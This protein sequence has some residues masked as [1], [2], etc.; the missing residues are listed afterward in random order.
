MKPYVV[1]FLLL[2]CC[3]SRSQAQQAATIYRIKID[4]LQVLIN[5]QPKADSNTVKW[6]NYVARVC[7]YDMQYQRGLLATIE[8]REL[9]KKLHYA[10]GEGLYWR[11]L[12]IF[13]AAPLAFYYYNFLAKW[14]YT[15]RKQQEE[16]VRLWAGL[17]GERNVEKMKAELL[18]ALTYFEKHLDH[19]V[20]A[21]VLVAYASLIK[22]NEQT[23][24][25]AKAI[26]LFR[27]NN[28]PIPPFFIA[29]VTMQLSGQAGNEKETKEA[30]IETRTILATTKD[31]REKASMYYF[32][33]QIYVN[34]G[35]KDLAFDVV[36]QADK[37]LE[38]FGEKELRINVLY[39]LGILCFDLSLHKK[40]ADYLKKAAILSAENINNSAAGLTE[41]YLQTAFSL[42]NLKEFKEA[43]YFIEKSRNAPTGLHSELTRRYNTARQYDAMG[44][45]LMGQGKYQ[46]ALKN[47]AQALTYANQ[48]GDSI[49]LASYMTYYMAQ[50]YQK[51]GQFQESIRYGKLSYEKAFPVHVLGTQRNYVITRT[52]LLLS[53]V[54]EE[55]GQPLEAYHYLKEYQKLRKEADQK[56]E[57]NHLL[58]VEIQAAIEKGEQEK[59]RLE[60]EQHLQKQ[61]ILAIEKQREIDQLKAQAQNQLLQA[62]AEQ[63]ELDKQLET[64][65]LEARALQNRRQQDYKIALLNLDIDTQHKVRTGLLGGLALFALFVIGLV[66]QNRVK[67]RFNQTLTKQKVE[68]E[69]QRDQLNETLTELKSTQA[70]LIEKEKL[71]SLGELTAGIAHEIQNPLNFVN[72]FSEVSTEL[73]EELKEEAQA[74]HAEDVLA[75]ADDL[76]SNLQKIHHH[77][78]RAAAIVRGMLEHSRT[79]SG[80][81]RPTDLNALADEYLKIAYHGLRAKDKNGSTDRFNCELVTD[82]AADLGRIE[83]VPQEIGRVLLNL[84]NNAFYAVQQRQRL[85]QEGY[86]QTVEVHTSRV[87]DRVLIRVKDNGM[88]IPEA[89][90]AKIFQPFF[91]TKPTGEGTGLGLS[92]SYDIVTKGHG[93]LLA[94]ES[95][96]GEGTEFRITLP[97]LQPS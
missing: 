13:N 68:I 31:S 86:Q 6:L 9:A 69:R 81:K 83:V 18:T 33:G 59:K 89:I 29:A 8:A 93:G 63:A 97:L 50:C 3:F 22:P 15:D 39:R 12:S 65:R 26:R 36:H 75:I 91:T 71:A 1:A 72:N 44:Q 90:K 51:L 43:S 54:Y 58:D 80:E 20:L 85:A 5:R 10:K 14:F 74:G 40:A 62:R 47:F 79:D 64:E 76:S 49:R 32:L 53:E 2:L 16:T 82:F 66:R 87:S 73:I 56:D 41:L 61:R 48:T 42:I 84:Y 21:N 30:E 78:D 11:T 27:E 35:R 37:L 28:Q 70:Q 57:A 77:G 4:S 24:Y 19:E 38:K 60:G 96:E 94:V 55:A 46:E 52:S 92:L 88:G 7:F 95:R 34:Q 45:L 25:S 23:A 17:P 67:Q